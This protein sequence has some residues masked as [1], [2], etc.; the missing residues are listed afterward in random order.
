MIID[1]STVPTG[2][3]RPLSVLT[4]TLHAEDLATGETRTVVEVLGQ[5]G[6]PV[7]LSRAASILDASGLTLLE[8]YIARAGL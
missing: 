4:L 8:S 5:D 1:I 6:E 2:A 3:P 7:P